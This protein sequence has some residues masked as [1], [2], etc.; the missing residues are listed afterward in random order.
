MLPKVTILRYSEHDQGT[1]GILI[2]PDGWVAHVLELPDRGNRSCVSR[3]P[4][5]EYMCTWY[6]S[7]K[8]GHKYLVCDVPGRTWIRI[9][10]GNYAGDTSLGYKSHSAGCI[11]LGKHKGFMHGQRAIMSSGITVRRFE[12][13]MQRKKFTLTITNV[14]G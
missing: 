8:Y 7:G 4:T 10:K 13:H 12:E 5:G 3:I 1:R 6:P 9:H 11:M 2:A 14:G